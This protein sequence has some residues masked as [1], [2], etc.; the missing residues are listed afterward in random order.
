MIIDNKIHIQR[1]IVE[2]S[3]LEDIDENNLNFGRVFSDHMFIADFSNGEWNN[4]RIIPYGKMEFS[5]A[6]MT[7]HYSQTIFEGLKAYR[8]D[9]GNIN[10]FRPLRNW[11]R[12]N[13]SAERIC[14]PE[15]PEEVF[16]GGLIELLRQDS[17][18]VP[19]Q[20]GQT[21]YIRP[22]MIATDEFIGLKSS[23]NYRFI[24][25]TSPVASYYSAAV[26][27]KIETHFTR[28]VEGGTGYAK[29]GGN[30]AASLYPAKLAKEEGYDQLIWT[31]G[32]THQYIE[33]AGTMNLMFK[34]NGKIITASL[35]DSVLAGVTRDSVLQI[36]RDTGI[37][38]E[39]RRI[40]I[41]EIVEYAQKGEIEEAFGVGTAATV[42]PIAL[43]GYEGKNYSMPEIDEN[44]FAFKAKQ[45]LVSLCRGRETD[46]FGWIYQVD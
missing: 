15:I 43:I 32:K 23:D 18:W 6:L 3:R 16:M 46:R 2:K 28:A 13:R 11:E 8:A 42:A 38:V 7:L 25:I 1:Q 37:T 30:Y 44:T 35:G 10:L 27:V 21:L 41:K 5:P 31:D 19:N 34:V 9:D 40:S 20:E 14:M 45:T 22:F 29:T 4:L 36:A 26:K 17:N 33:E 12:M 24:I 39:E